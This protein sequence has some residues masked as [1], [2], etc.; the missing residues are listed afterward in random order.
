[1]SASVRK[2]EPVPIELHRAADGEVRLAVPGVFEPW[3]CLRCSKENPPERIV[4]DCPSLRDGDD[5]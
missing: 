3:I 4:C 2:R 1:M 5:R